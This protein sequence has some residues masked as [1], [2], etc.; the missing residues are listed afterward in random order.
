VG[1]VVEG[2]AMRGVV[3]AGMLSGLESLGLL[4]CFDVVYGNSAGAIA[5]AYFVA[6]QM[7]FGTTVFYEDAN[8]RQCINIRRFLRT[9]PVMDL[10]FIFEDVMNCRKPLDWQAVIHSPIPLKAVAFSPDDMSSVLLCNFESKQELFD[11]LRASSSIP[12][13]TGPPVELGGKRFVDGGFSEASPVDSAVQDGCTHVLVLL[14]EPRGII[15]KVPLLL[16]H[17]LSFRFEKFARGLGNQFK[18][19]LRSYAT[20]IENLSF[21]PVGISG[22]AKVLPVFQHEGVGEISVFE[23][24]GERLRLGA[25]SGMKAILEAFCD[26][27][28]VVAHRLT[29]YDDRGKEIHS[30]HR[31][32]EN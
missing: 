32:S 11:S 25:A 30:V 22:E 23:K 17:Y 12:V 3:T 14:S 21:D 26:R 5:S 1:L 19:G 10:E 27:L 28:P 29:A 2:G 6:G 4:G 7:R 31:R 18:D 13:V 15:P 9:K 20:I 8:T 24:N 16:K